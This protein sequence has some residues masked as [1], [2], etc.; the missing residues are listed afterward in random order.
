MPVMRVLVPQRMS[1]YRAEIF[2]ANII[3]T[4]G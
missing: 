4:E 3:E 1:V 2:L